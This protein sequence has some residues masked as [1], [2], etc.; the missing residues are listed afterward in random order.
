MFWSEVLTNL[1]HLS[2]KYFVI[3]HTKKEILAFFMRRRSFYVQCSYKKK[4]TK[5][6]AK[7]RYIFHI[8]RARKLT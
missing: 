6:H 2:Y 8:N 1:F 3:P 4:T 5:A 7:H